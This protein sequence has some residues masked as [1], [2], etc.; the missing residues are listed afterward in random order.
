MDQKGNIRRLGPDDRPRSGEVL[1]TNAERVA[2]LRLEE[3]KRLEAL[4]LLR[5]QR[6]QDAPRNNSKRRRQFKEATKVRGNKPQV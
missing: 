2:L 1:L 3:S 5:A 6:K 4:A